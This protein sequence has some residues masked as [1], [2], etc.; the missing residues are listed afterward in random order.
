MSGEVGDKL[1]KSSVMEKERIWRK[2]SMIGQ[3]TAKTS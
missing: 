3:A 2:R 1:Q